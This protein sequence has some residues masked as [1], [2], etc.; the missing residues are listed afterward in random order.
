MTDDQES[1]EQTLETTCNQESEKPRRTRGWLTAVEADSAAPH[2]SQLTSRED[3]LEKAACAL[4]EALL[5]CSGKRARRRAE[6]EAI[7][8]T[9]QSLCVLQRTRGGRPWTAHFAEDET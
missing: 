2:W 1:S 6:R 4:A 9:L 7:L 5:N 3:V 8:G